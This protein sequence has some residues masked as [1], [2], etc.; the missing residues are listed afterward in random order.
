MKK[1][2]KPQIETFLIENSSIIALSLQD[3]EADPDKPVFSPKF[4]RGDWEEDEYD[5]DKTNFNHW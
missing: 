1:Y 4:R 3:G 5:K 2:I